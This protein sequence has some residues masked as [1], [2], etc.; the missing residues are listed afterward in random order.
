MEV[1]NEVLETRG[2]NTRSRASTFRDVEL[3]PSASCLLC[4]GVEMCPVRCSR[5]PRSFSLLGRG[6]SLKH[7]SAGLWSGAPHKGQY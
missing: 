5:S 4:S 2:P 6:A 1:D 7:L 3:L